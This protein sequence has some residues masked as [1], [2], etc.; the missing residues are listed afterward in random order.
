MSRPA[1]RRTNARALV[2]AVIWSIATSGLLAAMGSWS[3]AGSMSTSRRYHT[4]TLLAA[5]ECLSPVE[6]NN[7]SRTFPVP[8]FTIQR[9][10]PGRRRPHEHCAQ[11]PFCQS[12]LR[13]ESARCWRLE[14]ECGIGSRRDL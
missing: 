11:P 10:I 1:R 5:R 4:A 3:P 9:Q 13:R 8:R 7:N 14:R 2:I 12:A 6:Q